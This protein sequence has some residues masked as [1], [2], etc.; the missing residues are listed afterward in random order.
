[1]S[2]NLITIH[3]SK[4]TSSPSYWRES[5]GI[6][7]P[8]FTIEQPSALALYERHSLRHIR[9]GYTTV[10]DIR[11]FHL[12][13]SQFKL[14]ALFCLEPYEV[15]NFGDT[16]LLK[17]LFMMKKD[18]ERFGKQAIFR[19]ITD[20]ITYLSGEVHHNIY[21]NPNDRRRG[22]RLREEHGYD[23]KSASD[24][25]FLYDLLNTFLYRNCNGFFETYRS[26]RDVYSSL[27]K[28]I[29]EGEITVTDFEEMQNERK[30]QLEKLLAD[31]E[32]IK[33]LYAYNDDLDFQM[34]LKKLFMREVFSNALRGIEAYN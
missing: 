7:T 30:V 34:R 23:T 4:P 29:I 22:K 15:E 10:V 17:E 31:A 21:S 2:N 11:R 9:A 16:L 3:L 26:N 6:G 8:E 33:A 14:W 24:L 5:F 27:Y 32:V 19:N 13:L 20:A 28:S 18:F 1:M 25:L 12:A